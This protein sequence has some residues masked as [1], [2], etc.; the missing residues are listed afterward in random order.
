MFEGNEYQPDNRLSFGEH[1]NATNLCTLHLIYSWG[2]GK[3]LQQNHFIYKLWRIL[4]YCFIYLYCFR[5]Y[6]VNMVVMVNMVIFVFEK[7][8]GWPLD[9]F[10]NG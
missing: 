9:E 8:V 1:F 6:I 4:L 7:E 3:S 5:A 10:V 2:G